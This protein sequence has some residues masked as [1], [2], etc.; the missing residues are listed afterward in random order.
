MRQVLYSVPNVLVTLDG[1]NVV[2]RAVVAARALRAVDVGVAAV[3]GVAV[4]RATVFVDALRAVAEPLVFVT[5]L[6][7]IVPVRETV[8]LLVALRAELVVRETVFAESLRVTVV[9]VRVVVVC[10]VDVEIGMRVVVRAITVVLLSDD[11]FFVR[12]TVSVPRTAASA[13]AMP[14]KHAM[15]KSTVF[16]IPSAIYK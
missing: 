16:L 9:P 7:A 5:E 2:A 11:V 12:E 4:L 8:A 15:I 13:F 3:R 1:A 6:R 10:D 14:I